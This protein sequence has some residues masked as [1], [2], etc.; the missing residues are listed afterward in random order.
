MNICQRL[1][2]KRHGLIVTLCYL[3][4]TIFCNTYQHLGKRFTL[5]TVNYK[6]KTNHIRE[7]QVIRQFKTFYIHQLKTL[8][9]PRDNPNN[10][11]NYLLPAKLALPV[12]NIFFADQCH[13]NLVLGILANIFLI[14]FNK[15]LINFIKLATIFSFNAFFKKRVDK[16]VV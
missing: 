14:S 11:L 4:K 6:N 15:L 13:V 5:C 9:N 7:R 8:E 2:L 1:L 12:H 16:S 3:N 10:G